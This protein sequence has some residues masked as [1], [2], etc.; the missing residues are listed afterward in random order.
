MNRMRA[1][2]SV[3]IVVLSLMLAGAPSALAASRT[4]ATGPSLSSQ[5]PM[6]SAAT[7]TT[8]QSV[9]IQ[10]T[11]SCA[12]HPVEGIWLN[13]YPS[14]S[15]WI[16][17]WHWSSPNHYV[18]YFRTTLAIGYWATVQLNIGCGSTGSGWWSNNAPQST[19][20]MG[21][22]TLEVNCNEGT[23]QP[24]AGVGIR[25]TNGPTSAEAAAIQW[26]TG[27]RNQ[28]YD[29][30]QCLTFVY[31]AYGAAGIDLKQWQWVHYNI[32]SST[33]PQQMWPYIVAGLLDTSTPP[34]AGALVFYR[35]PT[36]YTY[37]HVTLSVGGGN[38]ISTADAFN[39]SG[40]HYETIAQHDSKAYSK[41][42]GWWL[43]A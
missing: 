4:Q 12:Y 7:A 16:S 9:T 10:G 14:G 26:A 6:F 41:Y 40:V 1:T 15:G 39:E 2:V 8:T 23:I 22:T 19:F 36:D 34:P 18:A 13:S 38:T 5:Q 35:D 43:P 32:T 20:V 21:S 31:A 37:S 27:H 11:V 24:P 33:Y 42:A 30:N 3:V 17:N 28:Q 29:Y 25:C